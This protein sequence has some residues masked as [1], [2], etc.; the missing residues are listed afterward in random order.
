MGVAAPCERLSRRLFGS[1]TRDFAGFVDQTKDKQ[2]STRVIQ[3][4]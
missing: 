3:Y 1:I 4:T 2:I